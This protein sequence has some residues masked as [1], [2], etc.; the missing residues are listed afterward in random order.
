MNNKIKKKE[1]EEDRS[2]HFGTFDAELI[3]DIQSYILVKLFDH[4]ILT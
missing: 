4:Y 3:Y 1:T 2:V